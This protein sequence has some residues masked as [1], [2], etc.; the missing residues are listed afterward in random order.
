MDSVCHKS[1]D[2]EDREDVPFLDSSDTNGAG[3]AHLHAPQPSIGK[4]P[5]A[6]S[7]ASAISFRLKVILFSMILAVEVGFAFLEGPMVRIMESIA[8]RQY[9]AAVDPTKIGADGQVPEAMCKIGEVQAELAAVKGYHMFFDGSL[10]RL[11]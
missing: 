1:L 9:F 10:S 3:P 5:E 8:C 2:R 6:N 11:I 7:S 4:R